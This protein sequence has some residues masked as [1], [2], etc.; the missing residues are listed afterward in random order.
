MINAHAIFRTHEVQVSAKMV[1]DQRLQIHPLDGSNCIMI[2][3]RAD[4]RTDSS[5]RS[6]NRLIVDACSMIDSGVVRTICNADDGRR[7]RCFG[8]KNFCC[9]PFTLVPLPSLENE[10]DTDAGPDVEDLARQ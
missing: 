2:G 5:M 7:G 4:V 1:P 3:L 8:H 9:R 10:F 6:S